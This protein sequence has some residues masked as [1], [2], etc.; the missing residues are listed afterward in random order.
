MRCHKRLKKE[1][2]KEKKFRHKWVTDKMILYIK[3][4]ALKHI[5]ISYHICLSVITNRESKDVQINHKEIAKQKKSKYCKNNDTVTV[6]NNT[7]IRL[8]LMFPQF[9][10]RKLVVYN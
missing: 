2:K 10:S 1:K 5:C 9:I 3:Y 8:K 4:F 7:V 6:Q